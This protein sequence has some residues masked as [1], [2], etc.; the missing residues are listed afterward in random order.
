[1]SDSVPREHFIETASL[2][3]RLKR[4]QIGRWF[5][6][7][8]YFPEQYV[9]PPSFDSSA[10][11]LRRKPYFK[12]DPT[13][14]RNGFRVDTAEMVSLSFPRSRLTERRFAI[15]HPK[16]YHDLVWYVLEDWDLILDHLFD[17]RL[18]LYSYSFPIPLASDNP[19]HIGRLR[20]GR[21]IYQFLEMAENDLV[22]EAHKYQ[23]ILKTDITNFY[24]SV[25]THSVG[26][27]LHGK[28]AV[29]NE[30]TRFDMVGKIL[31]K[32][33]QNANDGCTN[34]L[35]IGPAVSDFVSEIVLAAVDLALSLQVSADIDFVGVR[36]KDDYRFLCHT[37]EDAHKI[38]RALQLCL[39]EYNLTLAEKKSQV[40]RL[41]EG[42]FREWKVLYQ[43]YSLKKRDSITYD[44]FQKSLLGVLSVDRAVPGTGAIDG[45]LAELSTNDA[46][47]K[48]TLSPK[49]RTKAFSLLLLLRRRRPK[50]FPSVLA[51]AEALLKKYSEDQVFQRGVKRSLRDILEDRLGHPKDS[52]YEIL[53]LLYFFKVVFGQD[54]GSV[55]S[56]EHEL[57]ESERSSGQCFFRDFTDAPFFQIPDV[58]PDTNH[59]LRHL[60][61]F[62]SHGRSDQHAEE[63]L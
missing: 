33:C 54:L 41:P 6:E 47:M 23:F 17:T 38:V 35:A 22:A 52:E 8:G 32:L 26:W 55:E 58:D 7:A 10:F 18:R 9:L 15:Y 37:E 61:V 16:H 13:K 29:R 59:L 19:G 25:Y 44:E 24:P 50:C 49:Q 62:H 1:M 46:E 53:W 40:L 51:I 14:T 56:F 42:L 12:A 31:D 60:A 28:L 34:G 48:L 11:K 36:F 3:R 30:R 63:S 45:F 2:A 21:M 4:D 39:K 57:L 43:G 5:L 27:A 20:A